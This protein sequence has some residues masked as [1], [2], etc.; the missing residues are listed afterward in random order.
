MNAIKTIIID[1]EEHNRNLLSTLLKK[2]CPSIEICSEAVNADDAFELI[3][4]HK[5]KL[6]FLDIRM[7]GK[8]GFDLLRQFTEINFEVIFVSAFDEYAIAAFDFNALGYI[9]KP[10]DY[11]KLLKVIEKAINKIN[12]NYSNEDI[13]NFTKTISEKNEL[14]TK[15]AVHHNGRVIF[16]S[17]NEIVSVEGNGNICELKL[18]DNTCYF[19]SKDL[20]LFDNMLEKSGNFVRIN[21]SVIINI[22]YIKSYS[23]GDVCTIEL[24]N[25]LVYELPRRKKA[26]V[27]GKMKIIL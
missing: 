14:V 11:S 13:L 2:H 7:P 18:L 24:N 22:D 3:K 17:I 9:L 26:E 19:S 23:K 8:S 6:I 5:P 20:K 10:I 12:S 27:L 15:I 4:L 21:R 1:D 16:L 25:G